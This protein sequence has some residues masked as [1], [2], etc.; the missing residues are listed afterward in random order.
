V[1]HEYVYVL[2]DD[3]YGVSEVLAVNGHE[4][5][6]LERDGKGGDE[7]EC[8]RIYQIDLEGASEVSE[9]DSLPVGQL[10]QEIRPVK[11]A[12]L[13]DLLDPRFKIRGPG[14]PEKMEGLAFGPDLPDGRRLLILAC[15]SD[16]DETRPTVFYAF[17]V[18]RD[19]LPRFGWSSGQ[20]ALSSISR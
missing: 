16:F 5:L 15:D 18:D 13:V 12:L 10:P 20:A 6:V 4:F 7:A 11:K 9:C 17:A 3:S 14:C 8:K 1:T 2:D 19:D